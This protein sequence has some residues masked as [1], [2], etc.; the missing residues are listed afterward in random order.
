VVVKEPAIGGYYNSSALSVL[1][2]IP[3]GNNKGPRRPKFSIGDLVE[4][5]LEKLEGGKLLDVY[6][7]NEVIYR[8]VRFIIII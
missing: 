3:E 1:D 6:T 4:I 5:Q 7:G 8:W 2:T